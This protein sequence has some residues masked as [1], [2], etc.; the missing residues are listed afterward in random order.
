MSNRIKKTL[1][2]M[3]ALA[4]VLA[5]VLGALPALASDSAVTLT[6]LMQETEPITHYFT[7]GGSL[8]SSLD[9]QVATD[10]LSIDYLENLFLGLTNVNAVSAEIE[11]EL[12]TEWSYDEETF[13]WTFTIRDDVPWVRWDPVA[14]EVTEIRNVVAGDF[15]T[16]IRRAC[17]PN[18]TSLY[19]DVVGSNIAG[20]SAVYAMDPAEVTAED[21][22]SVGVAAPDDTTL[23][24]TLDGSRGYFFSMTPMWTLRAVPG[25]IIDEFGEPVGGDAWTQPGSIVTNGAY[26]LDE[27]ERGVRRVLV[28]N[29]LLPADLR[30]PGNVERVIDTV[31]EDAGTTYALFQDNQLDFSGVPSAELQNVLASDEADQVVQKVELTVFY[32]GFAHDKAPFDDVHAR[33]AFSASVNRELFVSEIL[34]GRGVPMMHFTPPGMFGSVAVN[35]V[36]IDGEGIGYDPAFAQSEIEAAGF[37]NCEGFPEINVVTY[38]GAQDW[39]EFVQ[40]EVENTLGC[41]P[42]AF[43]I[44]QQEFSVLL[45]TTSADTPTEERPNIWT[46]G[47]GPDYADA[48]NWVFDAGLHCES[49]N[50]FMRPC[51]EADDL[52]TEAQVETDPDTRAELY[53]QIE[54]MFFGYE[55]LHPIMPLYMRA[56][57]VQVRPWLQK[58]LE[59]DGLF[60]GEHYDYLTIDQELQLEARG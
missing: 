33:R 25:E 53:R 13:T 32:F 48:N 5:M 27:W 60:G 54:E 35:E 49:S 43:S 2:V 58:P 15:V 14:E 51:D 30:G 23:T 11:P 3:P 31:V 18:N 55:G 44:E 26:M 10:S 42:S 4:L 50:D 47:W 34:Q 9:P 52:I 22:E 38:S 37:P 46:L 1:R 29:P 19:S 7:N 57:F 36:G 16:G 56:G 20:C 41:D 40:A 28:T 6:G 21:F 8:I 39:A 17:D 45:Q 59:T 24:I 12:A